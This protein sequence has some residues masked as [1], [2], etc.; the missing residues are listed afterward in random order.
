VTVPHPDP[1]PLEPWALDLLRQDDAGTHPQTHEELARLVALLRALPDPKSSPDLAERIL[2]QV[3][4][5]EARPRVVRALFGAFGQ[6]A[7]PA[8]AAPLAAGIAA[9]VAVALSPESI[10]SVLRP[11]PT[12]RE[13]VVAAAA[14]SVARR[15]GPLIRPQYV[16]AAFAQTPSALPRFRPERSPIEDA[17]DARLDHQLNQLMLDP[18]AFAER[19]ELVDQRDRFMARLAER[20]VERGDAPEIAFRVRASHHPLAGQ[21]V[22]RLLGATLIQS[23]SGH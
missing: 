7:R 4:A 6:L 18:T 22:E 19:L 17:F 21:L 2:A 14:P 16:S 8:V 3:A 9:L 11:G 20:A 5:Q 23:A 12:I 13:Q 10:P 1:K 15:R